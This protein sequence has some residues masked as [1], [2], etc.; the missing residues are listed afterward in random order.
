M[1]ATVQPA[2]SQSGHTAYGGMSG[3]SAYTELGRTTDERIRHQNDPGLRIAS[4]RRRE[5]RTLGFRPSFFKGRPKFP[6]RKTKLP[7]P[8]AEDP[9]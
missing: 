6:G 5:S 9:R 7:D 2:S 3:A 1:I 4:E 8:P